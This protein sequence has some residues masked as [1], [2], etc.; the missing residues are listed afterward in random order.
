MSR[1]AVRERDELHLMPEFGVLGGRPART[2]IAIV[3][4]RPKRNHSQFSPRRLSQRYRNAKQD[5]QA[6]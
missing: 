2:V 1:I 5:R 3:R 6:A 4:V